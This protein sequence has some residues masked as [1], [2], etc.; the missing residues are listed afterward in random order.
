MKYFFIVLL[1]IV[2]AFI[3]QKVVV[4]LSPDMNQESGLNGIFPN[5][6]PKTGARG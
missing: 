1:F 5:I 4:N 2:S 6:T 3:D